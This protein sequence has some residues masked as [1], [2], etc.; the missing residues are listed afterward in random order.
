MIGFVND[1][2]PFPDGTSNHFV[3][4]RFA[5]DDIAG[6]ESE[7]Q[8]A[9]D[10]IFVDVQCRAATLE[11]W[12]ETSA[13]YGMNYSISTTDCRLEYTHYPNALSSSPTAR[14]EVIARAWIGYCNDD[15]HQAENVRIGLAVLELGKDIGSDGNRTLRR[16]SQIICSPTYK[17]M[18]LDMVSRGWTVQ[19]LTIVREL[20]SAEMENLT[21]ADM[22]GWIG[23]STPLWQSQWNSFPDICG[24]FVSLPEYCNQAIDIELDRRLLLALLLY[25]PTPVP[26][27]LSLFDARLLQDITARFFQQYIIQLVNAALTKPISRVITAKTRASVNRLLVRALATHLMVA[28]LVIAMSLVA[29]MAVIT[30]RGGILLQ[31]PNTIVGITLNIAEDRKTLQQLIVA[32][33]TRTAIA[34]SKGSEHTEYI[35]GADV[36][37]SN[38]KQRW[39]WA[40]LLFNRQKQDNLKSCRNKPAEPARSHR[41]K[42]GQPLATHHRTRFVVTLMVLCL[43][44]ILEIFLR[45]SQR[46]DGVA[47]IV[48]SDTIFSYLWTFGPIIISLLLAGYQASVDFTVRSRQSLTNM[49]DS[50]GAPY[51]S[52]IGLNLID[53]SLPAL[54]VTEVRTKSITA[55]CATVASLLASLLPVFSA[56]L[57]T[58]KS[59]QLSSRNQLRLLN[60]FA[61]YLASNHNASDW[62]LVAAPLI[63]TKNMSYTAFTYEDLVLPCLKL[64][65]PFTG[66]GTSGASWSSD[67]SFNVAARV[68]ALRPRLNCKFYDSSMVEARLN[69]TGGRD[70]S[71]RPEV[72]ISGESADCFVLLGSFGSTG[73]HDLDIGVAAIKSE[74]P[75][76][77]ESLGYA[78][79]MYKCVTEYIYVWGTFTPRS[80]AHSSLVAYGCNETVEAVEAR[81]QL[82]GPDLR[83]DPSTPPLVV[84]NDVAAAAH[85]TAIRPNRTR[86]ITNLGDY[87]PADLYLNTLPSM[88]PTGP[89]NFDQFF[90]LLTTTGSRLSF[91]RSLLTDPNQKDRVAEAIR[92]Q[93]GIIRAQS[94]STDYRRPFEAEGTV[95]LSLGSPNL[96]HASTGPTSSPAS[97]IEATVTDPHGR[98][99][100]IQDARSTRIL[101]GLLG[102]ILL[103]STAGWI[104]LAMSSADQDKVA[105]VWGKSPTCIMNVMALLAESNIFDLLPPS[106]DG[107]GK[108]TEQV[109]EGCRF[110]LEWVEGAYT[111]TSARD[112]LEMEIELESRESE[113]DGTSG[114]GA[115]DLEDVVENEDGRSRHRLLTLMVIGKDGGKESGFEAGYDTVSL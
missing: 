36:P 76:A 115:V 39:S 74:M 92:H 90:L 10:G 40:R 33:P 99:R 98:T 20:L 101:E 23:S 113:S 66:N 32:K 48:A 8:A 111:A 45:K 42:P 22:V 44:T 84:A 5:Y 57:L 89:P 75:G 16:S 94:L 13:G 70:G 29:L 46:D 65:L 49:C 69:T 58:T 82:V 37:D 85:K 28:A 19:N 79:Q 15:R 50:R 87:T 2:L 26:G 80:P 93:H 83:V 18:E 14:L 27:P 31:R 56:S 104:L 71:S 78:T 53:R 91:P 88:I 6:P 110:K 67:G 43:I 1:S 11:S 108:G 105:Q 24:G 34:S 25:G 63:L 114:R 41:S 3:H 51:H 68:P 73:L 4:Q 35:N 54:I 81:V 64:D 38:I 59:T 106:Q 52:S 86:A 97:V 112:S 17:M 107:H 21:M 9:V 12:I 30:P 47:E 7:V 100:L 77:E 72:R 61:P 55:L 60:S 96:V 109:F 95:K 62:G 102:A 103:F